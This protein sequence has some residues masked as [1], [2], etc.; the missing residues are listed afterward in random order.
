[1]VPII[2]FFLGYRKTYQTKYSLDIR[3]KIYDEKLEWLQLQQ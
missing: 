2:I 1:M 3:Q